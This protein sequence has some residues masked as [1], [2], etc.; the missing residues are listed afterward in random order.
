MQM[1]HQRTDIRPKRRTGLHPL[2]RWRGK[3]TGAARA[4]AAMQVDAG[5]NRLDW[6]Q[7]DM[8]VC[9]DVG[10][11]GLGQRRRAMRALRGHRF[12]HAVGIDG[13]RTGHTG[14][15]LASLGLTLG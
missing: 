3:P 13:K 6:W 2:W 8:V 11:V 14:A 7:V 12:D 5:G 9:M 1:D 15:A 4:D 10:L